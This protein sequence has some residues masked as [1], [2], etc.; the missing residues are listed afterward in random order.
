MLSFANS[1]ILSFAKMSHM[2]SAY[3]KVEIFFLDMARYFGSKVVMSLQI[4]TRGYGG[5]ENREVYTDSIPL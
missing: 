5:G 2:T 3:D 1:S 4:F